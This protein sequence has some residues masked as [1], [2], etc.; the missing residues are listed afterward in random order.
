MRR[1]GV[2]G[3]KGSKV[4][5][6]VKLYVKRT[7]HRATE[8]KVIITYTSNQ[9]I[10]SAAGGAPQGTIL[11][12]A[13]SQGT[14]DNQR[15]GNKLRCVRGVIKGQVNLL[16]YNAVTNPNTTPLWVKIWVVRHLGIAG[17]LSSVGGLDWTTFFRGNG[18]NL[19]FQGTTLDMNLPVNNDYWK[20]E[21]V[22]S[23][24]LGATSYSATGPVTSGGY[25]DNSHMSV[26]FSF[27]YG[28]YTKKQLK[29]NDSGTLPTNHN[30]YLV[31]TVVNADG[32]SGAGYYPAEYHFVNTFQFEDA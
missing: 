12:P 4:S 27:S 29:F 15:I 21:A 17:Q 11:L 24:R 16:P 5:K 1:R 26:P 7:M 22:R 31:I 14:G 19:P 25:F 20:V 13:I 10:Y 18:F 8:N 6:A 3:G 2:R 28:R 30:L 23:F 32:T 9:A